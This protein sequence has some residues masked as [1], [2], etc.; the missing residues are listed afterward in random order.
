[1]VPPTRPSVASARPRSRYSRNGRRP[2]RVHSAPSSRDRTILGLGLDM[3][4]PVDRWIGAHAS[5]V[6]AVVERIAEGAA[7]SVG[8]L[9][10][11]ERGGARGYGLS[12]DP[13]PL[14]PTLSPSGRGSAPSSRHPS[15]LHILMKLVSD[16][17]RQDEMASSVASPTH[18]TRG[19]TCG[20]GPAL[21]ISRERHRAGGGTWR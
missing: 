11:R 19:P 5:A 13:A 15:H 9:S 16:E 10:H 14:T 1:M 21:P 20:V 2:L 17:I 4:P 8:S 18:L 3:G 12:I 7:N 6:S